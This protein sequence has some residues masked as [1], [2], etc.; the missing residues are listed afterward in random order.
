MADFL[1]RL[2]GRTL[3]LAPTIQPMIASM[4][5]PGQRLVGADDAQSLH[6]LASNEA[7]YAELDERV[8][9]PQWRVPRMFPQEGP[10]QPATRFREQVLPPLVLEGDQ[11]SMAPVQVPYPSSG[12][13]DVQPVSNRLKD[14]VE[15]SPGEIPASRPMSP[16]DRASV[17]ERAPATSRKN[18]SQVEV[19]P[20]HH[21]HKLATP[22]EA[23]REAMEW[24]GERR[25]VATP[26]VGVV[27]VGRGEPHPQQRI[28]RV[29]PLDHPYNRGNEHEY[30]QQSSA[31][32][33]TIQVTIGRI[34]V[35]A[36][37]PANPRPQPRRAEPPVMGLEEYLNQR[38]KGGY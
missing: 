10:Q 1:T 3:G 20:S 25:N 7:S 35:R 16:E 12:M 29:Q 18:G 21:P 6:A 34:E 26:L 32:E 23:A 14:E 31:P 33:P 5:A 28:Q 24:G 13:P 38:A 11:P 27:G 9:Y 37:P 22:M 4:F 36:M 30:A 15:S 8:T 17:R 19:S 2:A